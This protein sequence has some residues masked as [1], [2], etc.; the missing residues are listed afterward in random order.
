MIKKHLVERDEGVTEIA[1]CNK[2]LWCLYERVKLW[3]NDIGKSIEKRR[4]LRGDLL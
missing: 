2:K 1:K 4:D 3:K